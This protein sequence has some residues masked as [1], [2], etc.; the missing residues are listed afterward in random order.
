MS[1]KV[2]T[3]WSAPT[4]LLLTR[5]EALNLMAL[6]RLFPSFREW[7]K[8]IKASYVPPV[9][10]L[11]VEYLITSWILSFL[12]RV[13]S[14]AWIGEC[15]DG[16]HIPHPTSW[17]KDGKLPEVFSTSRGAYETLLR[18]LILSIPNVLFVDGTIMEVKQSDEI[19][20][21]LEQVIY[22]TNTGALATQE[23][24][25]VVGKSL[26]C[27]LFVEYMLITWMC[28]PDCTGPGHAGTTWLKRAGFSVPHKESYNPHLRYY[29]AEYNI[30][31]MV[32]A[33]ILPGGFDR[34]KP[35]IML[36]GNKL[37]R[38]GK[39][40][41]ITQIEDDRSKSYYPYLLE[42]RTLMFGKFISCLVGGRSR[43]RL[44]PSPT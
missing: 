32:M 42:E 33:K 14:V 19:L 21:K 20:G 27:V 37:D 43:M 29:T 30:D 17:F 11:P 38:D 31:P 4:R 39:V 22:R 35:Y 9:F 8:T 41:A 44:R 5:L 34:S 36:N 2:R 3:R 6:D 23:A 24:T 1:V 16:V 15:K 7:L 12:I 28:I 13:G 40:L 10:Y 18:R 25:L 26:V